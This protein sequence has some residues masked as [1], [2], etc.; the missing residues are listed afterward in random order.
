[1]GGYGTY[2]RGGPT[3]EEEALTYAPLLGREISDLNDDKRRW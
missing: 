2:R 3:Q 1:M